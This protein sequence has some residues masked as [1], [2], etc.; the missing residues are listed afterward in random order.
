MKR[1]MASIANVDG[2]AAKLSFEDGV[3]GL[4]LHVIG[5]LIEVADAG[6]VTFLLLS[7]DVSMVVNDHSRVVQ[8]F[9][10]SFPLED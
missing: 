9:L 2:D 7:E 4:S 8:R 3:S 10:Y 6:N 5:G 1:V